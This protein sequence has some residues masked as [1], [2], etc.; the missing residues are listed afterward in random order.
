MKPPGEFWVIVLSPCRSMLGQIAPTVTYKSTTLVTTFVLQVIRGGYKLLF[1]AC[2][3]LDVSS[4][5]ALV[6]SVTRESPHLA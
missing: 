4:A 5:T 1:S 3:L 2:C 6:A